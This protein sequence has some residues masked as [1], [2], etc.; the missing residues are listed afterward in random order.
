MVAAGRSA[1]RPRGLQISRL[2][3][4]FNARGPDG[5]VAM[6]HR[7]HPRSSTPCR[8]ALAEVP[9]EAGGPG[10]RRRR[11][12]RRR[13]ARGTFDAFARRDHGRARVKAL[14]SRVG[15]AASTRKTSC[16]SRTVAA[17]RRHSV[18]ECR[19]FPAELATIRALRKR[20]HVRG[21]IEPAGQKNKLTRRWARRHAPAARDQRTEW[22]SY[23][24]IPRRG[25]APGRPGATPTP[26]GAPHRI[27]AVVIPAPMRC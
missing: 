18:G 15:A 9:L 7:A 13:V 16:R 17:R 25:K 23:G 11:A 8:R 22:A 19:S 10:G 5:L 21:K 26:G 2:N 4:G 3:A 6:G 20:V 1:F 24:A 14:G 27:S 12:W